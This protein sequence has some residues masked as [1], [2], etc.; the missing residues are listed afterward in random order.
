MNEKS[1]SCGKW[2]EYT[3]PYSHALVV[4]RKNGTR[5]D[6]YVTDIY[7]QEIY[8]RTYQS[9][10]FWVGHKD[11]WRDVP[12][13]LTFYPPHMNNQQGRKQGTRFQVEMNYQ[14]PDSLPR[15]SRCRIPGHNK[16]IIVRP[17]GR[18]GDDDLD[19]VMERTGRVQGRTVT[20]SSRDYGVSSSEPFIERHSADMFFEEAHERVNDVGDGDDHDHDDS[21]DAGD[22]EQ[23][24]PVAPASGSD[25]R[26]RHEKGKGLTGSFMSVMNKISGSQEEIEGFILGADRP[27]RGRSCCPGAHPSYRGHDHGLLKCRSRYMA[28][29]GWNVTDAQVFPLATGQAWIYMY[30]PIFAP[31]VRPDTQPCKPYIQQYPTLGYKF[32]HKLLDIRLQLDMMTVDEVRH[33]GPQTTRCTCRAVNGAGFTRTRVGLYSF[34]GVRFKFYTLAPVLV[35]VPIFILLYGSGQG[36]KFLDPGGSGL[37]IEILYLKGM[38]MGM[39]MDLGP[40][41]SFTIRVRVWV[42]EYPEGLDPFTGLCT[43]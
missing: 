25:R 4:C 6:A 19:P 36:I 39:G 29:I 14:N 18:R 31:A 3:L 20:A 35:P 11:F 26:P 10:F 8:I 13:N 22:E 17:S 27:S 21:E 43:W 42:W 40:S 12:Y 33:A 16:K 28:L 2:R 32:E 34:L 9:N 37:G 23:P 5:P 41:P 7:S 15:C 24:M 38:G 1:C 30:F